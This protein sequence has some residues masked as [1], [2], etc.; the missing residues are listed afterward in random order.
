MR[1]PHFLPLA[2]LDDQH[3]I[4]A[5]RHGVVHLTWGRV[6]VRFGRDEFKRLVG[7]L[8]RT[9]D[10]LPPHS[11]HDG[12]LRVTYRQDE[13]CELQMG[14]LILLLSPSGFGEFVETAREALQRLDEILASGMWDRDE[15]EE[16]TPA[17]F[18]EQ[19]R[20]VPFSRN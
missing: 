19:F 13:D 1:T 3:F 8:E 17:S 16:D 18:L 15:P 2:Q 20:R 11:T 7:L 10:A 6:T 12:D 14:S 5:C 4:T 9:T